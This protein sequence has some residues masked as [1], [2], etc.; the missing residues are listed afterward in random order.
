ML[1][2]GLTNKSKVI[3]RQLFIGSGQRIEYV[4]IRAA[5]LVYLLTKMCVYTS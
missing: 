2:D 4:D 1:E 5:Y 3:C